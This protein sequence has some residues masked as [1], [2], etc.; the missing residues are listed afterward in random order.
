MIVVEGRSSGM[1]AARRAISIAAITS[2]CLSG[3]AASQRD[4]AS[5]AYSLDDTKVCRNFLEDGSKISSGYSSSA[6]GDEKAYLSALETQVN[7]RSLNQHKCETLVEQQNSKIVGGILI[8]AAAIGAAALVAKSRGG[9]GGAPY[10][11]GYA[12]DQFYDKNGNLTWRC[13][14]K[15]NGRFA[16]NYQCASAYKTDATWPAK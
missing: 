13:R 15:S 6:T 5:S 2:L 11:T 4:F 9:G 12:W 16:Y 3:C 10:A 14:D 8:G 7:R 1:D